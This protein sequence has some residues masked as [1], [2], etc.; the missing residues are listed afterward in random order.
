M[1]KP[2]K[3]VEVG[4]TVEL[5]L[6]DGVPDH[7]V[8]ELVQRL[9]ARAEQRA[10]RIGGYLLAFTV[11]AV[12]RDLTA[13]DQAE[14][15]NWLLDLPGISSLCLGALS[16]AA[17]R[18]ASPPQALFVLGLADEAMLPL[19]LLYRSGLV[20]PDLYLQLATNLTC[21]VAVLH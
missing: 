2:R 3:N 6:Q 18:S 9:R 20:A 16:T 14:M 21:Q 15:V 5:R 10:L 13:A 7:L 1:A 8:H 12:G 4:F 19:T 17:E 11:E